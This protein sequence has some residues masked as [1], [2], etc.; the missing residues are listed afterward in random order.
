M[1]AAALL[2]GGPIACG[3][4]RPDPTQD[5]PKAGPDITWTTAAPCPLA[6][7][8]ANGVVAGDELWVLGGFVSSALD[9]TGRADIYNPA[10]DSC[11]VGPPLPGAQ[12]HVAAAAVDGTD[13]VVAPARRP[14]SI[15]PARPSWVAAW[16]ARIEEPGGGRAAIPAAAADPVKSAA[17]CRSRS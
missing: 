15:L 3:G 14:R 11:R 17:T 12:T 10:T 7:F 2:A 8:E 4:A 6:R 9:V 5:V 13:V 1:A 16:P